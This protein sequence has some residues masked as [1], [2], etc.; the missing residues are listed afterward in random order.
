MSVLKPWNVDFGKSVYPWQIWVLLGNL[1]TMGKILDCEN[2]PLIISYFL[3]CLFDDCS[4]LCHILPHLTKDKGRR[5][6]GEGLE[7]EVSS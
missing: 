5:T 4:F 2:I 6:K 7:V 3:N 1:G